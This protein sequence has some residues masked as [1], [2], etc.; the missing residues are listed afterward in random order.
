MQSNPPHVLWQQTRNPAHTAS[1]TVLKAL[2][3]IP[4]ASSWRLAFA[5]RMC[6]HVRVCVR[7]PVWS[8]THR[9]WL[10]IYF[11]LT[12]WGD[13]FSKGVGFDHLPYDIRSPSPTHTD[14]YSDNT[15]NCAK[16]T[17]FPH[18]SNHYSHSPTAVNAID[19]V[20]Y[21]IVWKLEIADLNF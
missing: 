12:M 8:V 2:F 20:Y 21:W 16:V 18:T 17:S 13:S 1:V 9:R 3:W 19:N 6:G 7:V 5:T 4:P 15:L 10:R 11:L 14:T